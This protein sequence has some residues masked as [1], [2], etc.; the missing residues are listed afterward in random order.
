MEIATRVTH[1][2][3]EYFLVDKCKKIRNMEDNTSEA[4]YWACDSDMIIQEWTSGNA[5]IDYGIKVTQQISIVIFKAS[6]SQEN[7]PNFLKEHADNHAFMGY[8]CDP[9]SG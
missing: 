5:D 1:I 7:S 4:W 6:G 8:L 9:Y 3:L 2:N